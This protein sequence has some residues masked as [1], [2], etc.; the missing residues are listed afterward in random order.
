MISVAQGLGMEV[1]AEGIESEAQANILDAMNCDILQ[2]YYIGK[3]VRF[4]DVV[5]TLKT[6]KRRTVTC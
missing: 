2:G 1:V 3:P 6:R 5:T 4:N